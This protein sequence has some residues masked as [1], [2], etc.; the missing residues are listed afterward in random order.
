MGCRH[1]TMHVHWRKK[2][3][4][5]LTRLSLANLAT[6]SVFLQGLMGLPC[7]PFSQP[8]VQVQASLLHDTRV[9]NAAC[10]PADRTAFGRATST[11]RDTDNLRGS[12]EFLDF[13]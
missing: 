2:V 11:V 7:A 6:A 12:V 1:G 5:A 10:C 8:S 4:M 9:A 3:G 13:L